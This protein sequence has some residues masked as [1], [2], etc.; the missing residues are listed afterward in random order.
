MTDGFG[1]ATSTAHALGDAAEAA[2]KTATR[3]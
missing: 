3:L 1:N 2:V